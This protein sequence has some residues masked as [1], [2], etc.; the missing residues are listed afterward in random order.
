[1]RLRTARVEH[2]DGMGIG[3][4]DKGQ[5]GALRSGVNSIIYSVRSSR[6]R[7]WGRIYLHKKRQRQAGEVFG[8]E[9]NALDAK[10]QALGGVQQG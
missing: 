1:M 9:C 4:G 5:A 3:S 2:D 7:G 10:A 6:K 8:L